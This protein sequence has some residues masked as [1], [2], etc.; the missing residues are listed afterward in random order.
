[1]IKDMIKLLIHNVKK[2]FFKLIEINFLN[3]DY[4]KQK[5][6]IDHFKYTK[7]ISN[8]QRSFYQYKCQVHLTNF[9]NILLLNIICFIALPFFIIF[10]L[11]YSKFNKKKRKYYKL[12]TKKE[13]QIAVCK[14][15]NR[16][17]IPENI[18]N[19][20]EIVSSLNTLNLKVSDFSFFLK[21]VLFKHPFHYYFLIKILIKLANYSSNILVFNPNAF[22]VSS[23][24][25][26]T[27]SIITLYLE[28]NGIKHINVQ[29]GDKFYFIRDSFFKFSEFYIWD[30]YY[31]DLFVSL[32]A[33]INQFKV[34]PLIPLDTYFNFKIN[35]EIN[36]KPMLTYYLQAENKKDLIQLFI[37]LNNIIDNYNIIIRPHP[38]YQN[39]NVVNKIFK[40]YKIQN[41]YE[42]PINLSIIQTNYAVSKYSTVLYQ[43][44]ISNKE[45]VIDDLSNKE[46]FNKIKQLKYIMF[47][48]K[49]ILLSEL[50]NS[51]K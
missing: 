13:K 4:N 16:D 29:H 24:Y 3:T 33:D 10:L 49:H 34:K 2:L 26:F 30:H 15:K 42:V 27:S 32:K 6:Y 25:S 14:F 21:N 37:L 40:E 11:L 50:V 46:L 28:N 1:M 43:A 41:P 47:E 19:R 5:K 17:I 18:I 38:L 48:K 44:F 12:I 39:V 35:N 20:Y 9:L 8:I 22:I 36:L 45:A 51:K 23:E 31:K 7:N